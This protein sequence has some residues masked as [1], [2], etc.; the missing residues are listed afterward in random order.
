ML[1]PLHLLSQK[2]GPSLSGRMEGEREAEV[3]THRGTLRTRKPS[4]TFLSSPRSP[5]SGGAISRYHPSR[6]FLA[7]LGLGLVLQL[8]L[9][10]VL[11]LCPDQQGASLEA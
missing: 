1:H 7:L 8:L 11:G 4:K 5:S 6:G 9:H 3:M 10:R 2:A